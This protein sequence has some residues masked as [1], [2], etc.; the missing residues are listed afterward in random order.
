MDKGNTVSKVG[1]IRFAEKYAGKN[2]EIPFIRM[3]YKA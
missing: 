2:V 1:I 3:F